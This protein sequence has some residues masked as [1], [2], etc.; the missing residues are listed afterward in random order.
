MISQTKITQPP[1]D[2]REASGSSHMDPAGMKGIR[3]RVVDLTIQVELSPIVAK[4]SNDINTW[5]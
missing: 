2:V 5:W 3:S 1:N 4:T